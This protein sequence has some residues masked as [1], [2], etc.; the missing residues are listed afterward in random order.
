MLNYLKRKYSTFIIFSIAPLS[1]LVAWLVTGTLDSLSN[2]YTNVFLITAAVLIFL[3]IPVSDYIRERI[4]RGCI[5]DVRNLGILPKNWDKPDWKEDH[6]GDDWRSLVDDRVRKI[7]DTFSSDAKIRLAVNFYL[8]ADS[9]Y[10][11]TMEFREMADR[12]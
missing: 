1:L 8:I 5:E 12:D 3:T 6:Q 10:S 4:L 7:W 2:E 9:Q 11:Q